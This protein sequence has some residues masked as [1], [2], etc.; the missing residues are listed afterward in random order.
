MEGKRPSR[1]LGIKFSRRAKA[2]NAQ[3]PGSVPVT[4]ETGCF[5]KGRRKII[6]AKPLFCR[7]EEKHWVSRRYNLE[8]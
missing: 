7:E 4:M 6:Q 5:P 1:E 8:I 3:D 2:S